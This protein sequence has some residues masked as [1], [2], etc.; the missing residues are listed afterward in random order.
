VCNILN[1]NAFQDTEKQLTKCN[2]DDDD[3]DII[4]IIILFRH[5]FSFGQTLQLFLSYIT[6]ALIFLVLVICCKISEQPLHSSYFVA[7]PIT[8]SVKLC[9]VL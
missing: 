6:V 7:L 5:A 8:K 3:D 9:Y 4:I 2:D 1:S